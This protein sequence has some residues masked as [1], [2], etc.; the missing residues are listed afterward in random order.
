MSSN[1][2]QSF[3]NFWLKTLY[4]GVNAT[5]KV[6]I[7]LAQPDCE[8]LVWL[9]K[10]SAMETRDLEAIYVLD[11]K[12]PFYINEIR[13]KHPEISKAISEVEV[14]TSL[15]MIGKEIEKLKNRLALI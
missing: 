4:R 3:L 11:T 15:G 7:I 10:E 12:L 2:D 5:N 9:K 14:L 1:S 13:L 6:D 8:A